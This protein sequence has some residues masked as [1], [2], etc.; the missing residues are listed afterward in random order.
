M[1]THVCHQKRETERQK[2]RDRD[3]E[4]QRETQRDT[5]RFVLIYRGL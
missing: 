3:T 1:L 2:E 4:R 5:E